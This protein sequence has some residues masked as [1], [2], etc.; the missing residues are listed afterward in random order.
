MKGRCGFTDERKGRK[1]RDS[2]GLDINKT[3]YNTGPSP[4]LN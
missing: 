3:G 1:E 4:L 2:G